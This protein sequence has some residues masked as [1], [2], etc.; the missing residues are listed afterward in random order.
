MINM[1]KTRRQ[2]RRKRVAL[3]IFLCVIL[4]AAALGLGYRWSQLR[5]YPY[6]YQT[7][8]EQNA[9]KYGEDPLFIASVIRTESSWKP[10]AASSV[11]AKGLMQIMPNTGKEIATKNKW[12]YS[13][14]KLTDPAFSIQLGCWYIDHLSK[15][16]NGDKT[17]ILAAYNAGE[18]RV[19]DW[20][21]KGYFKD[22]YADIPYPET[23][24]YVGK[25]LNAYEKYKSLYKSK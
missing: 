1:A 9:A 2:G 19:R 15:N 4:L 11:G 22:G 5:A 7:I 8:I 21:S 3:A 13:E 23:R 10:N 6:N 20:V 24:S 16:F 12:E 17:L 14:E 18:S 25:V